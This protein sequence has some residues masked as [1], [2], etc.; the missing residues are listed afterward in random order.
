MNKTFAIILGIITGLI[1]VLYLNELVKGISALLLIKQNISL[2]FNGIS[3]QISFP[4]NNQNSFYTYLLVL[5][6][7]FLTNVLFIEISFIWLNKTVNDHLRSSIIIF[8][9]INI[10]YLIFAAFIGILSII[11]DSSYSTEWITILNQENLSYNQKLIFMLFVLI[12]LLGYI[13]IL[14][15]RIKRNIPT[16]K[17][18]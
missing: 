9:L 6:T 13:N 4:M 10:G 11:L 16:I 17:L 12:L 15:K 2:A 7:P 8:Q 18:K 3:L 5:I 1:A 14:T